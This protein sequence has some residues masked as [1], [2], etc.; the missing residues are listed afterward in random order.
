MEKFSSLLEVRKMI[1]LAVT[2]L[3][4]VL[5]V[6]GKIETKL[7]EYVVVSV[8]SYYF[9]KSTALDTPQ[10]QDGASEQA[11]IFHDEIRG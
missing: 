5:A 1:S 8:I 9:A 11:T 7:V 6:M 10:A 4:I 2:L 3:F